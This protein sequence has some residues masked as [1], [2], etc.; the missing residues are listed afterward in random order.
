MNIKLCA[1]VGQI[2][3]IASNP[4]SHQKKLVAH[5]HNIASQAKRSHILP[6]LDE[7]YCPDNEDD[8]VHALCVLVYKSALKA[9]ENWCSPAVKLDF[10]EII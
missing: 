10:Y 7:L 4:I 8:N 5:G 6:N 9:W 2:N 3:D 1:W